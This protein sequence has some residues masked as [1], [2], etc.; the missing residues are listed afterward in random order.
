MHNW[1]KTAFGE[2][3]ATL[4]SNRADGQGN[5]TDEKSIVARSLTVD[6]EGRFN[7]PHRKRTEFGYG[8][9]HIPQYIV[10]CFKI[11]EIQGKAKRSQALY[12]GH[13]QK[14][15]RLFKD[16]SESVRPK[17]CQHSVSGLSKSTI[18]VWF[19]SDGIADRFSCANI[20]ES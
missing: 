19:G 11:P 14:R 6:T 15:I 20:G 13:F 17:Q 1:T 10:R 12:P 9:S 5:G 18:V 7:L 3:R 16:A 2:M 8:Q 4:S